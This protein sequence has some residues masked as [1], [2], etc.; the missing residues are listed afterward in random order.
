VRLTPLIADG[1]NIRVADSRRFNVDDHVIGAWIP[2][3]DL[4]DLLG[5]LWA[6]LLQYLGCNSHDGQDTPKTP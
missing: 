3:L 6:G 4:D 2:T 1:M 5:L